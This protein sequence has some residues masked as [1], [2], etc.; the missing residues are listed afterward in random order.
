MLKTV[1]EQNIP[2]IIIALH[3]DGAPTLMVRATSDRRRKI[4]VAIFCAPTG[5][6][7]HSDVAVSGVDGDV[8]IDGRGGG[9]QSVQNFG[10]GCKWLWAVCPDAARRLARRVIFEPTRIHAAHLIDQLHAQSVDQRLGDRKSTR[11]NS[12]HVATSYAVL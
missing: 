5:E 7:L 9:A 10:T 2:P 4:R 12:S 11:L 8:I 1:R 6:I 3:V